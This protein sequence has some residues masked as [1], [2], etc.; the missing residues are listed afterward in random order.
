MWS[1]FINVYMFLNIMYLLYF[2]AIRIHTY[3]YICIFH[4]CTYTHAYI[5]SI[6]QLCFWNF[7]YT[8]WFFLLVWSSDFWVRPVKI[9]HSDDAFVNF[10]CDCHFGLYVFWGSVVRCLQV[11]NCYTF[12]FRLFFFFLCCASLYPFNSFFALNSLLFDNN[13]MSSFLWLVLPGIPLS[14]YFLPAF[15]CCF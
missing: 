5:K 7:L 12:F 2:L 8:C 14:S 3:I 1:V 10:S 11:P 6:L 4:I 13:I 15:L 9:S